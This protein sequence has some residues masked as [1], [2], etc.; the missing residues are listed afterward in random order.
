MRGKKPSLVEI[1]EAKKDLEKEL[2][3][4]IDGNI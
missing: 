1:D 2:G 3:I 4:K